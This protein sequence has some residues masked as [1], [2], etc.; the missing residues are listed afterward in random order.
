MEEEASRNPSVGA[1]AIED[2]RQLY[3][4]GPPECRDT[5][6]A[7]AVNYISD[8]IGVARRRNSFG[9]A[10]GIASVIEANLDTRL[11]IQPV[12]VSFLYSKQ[13]GTISIR[14]LRIQPIPLLISPAAYQEC[15]SQFHDNADGCG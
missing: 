13:C 9:A 11:G 5:V 3:L 10:G 1:I 7:S 14:S 2:S 6:T 12:N 4:G 8:N 15:I